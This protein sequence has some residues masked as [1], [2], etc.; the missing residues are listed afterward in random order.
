MALGATIRR[1]PSGFPDL[2]SGGRMQQHQQLLLLLLH[3]GAMR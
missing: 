2:E 1:L 3:T